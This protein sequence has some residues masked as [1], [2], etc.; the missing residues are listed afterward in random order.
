[1]KHEKRIKMDTTPT[2]KS[3]LKQNTLTI[4]IIPKLVTRQLILLQ[5]VSSM[6]LFFIHPSLCR[7]ICFQ[8]FPSGLYP[9]YCRFIIVCWIPIFYGS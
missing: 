5:L 3:H 8:V 7:A 9:Q 1:M 2:I 6:W 4:I